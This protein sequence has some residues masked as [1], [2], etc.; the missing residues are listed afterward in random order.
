MVEPWG[1][2]GGS[3]WCLGIVYFVAY[4]ARRPAGC[5]RPGKTLVFLP[6]SRKNSSSTKIDS[7]DVCIG[8]T[9]VDVN[10]GVER[11]ALIAQRSGLI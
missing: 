2:H 7:S 5:A 9:L 6:F 1:R 4:G 10:L 8:Q 11:S 3:H